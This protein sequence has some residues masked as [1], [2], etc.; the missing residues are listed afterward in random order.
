[1]KEKLEKYYYAVLL[2]DDHKVLKEAQ[3]M[4][5]EKASVFHISSAIV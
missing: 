3:K 2:D 5:G 1:M 4:L